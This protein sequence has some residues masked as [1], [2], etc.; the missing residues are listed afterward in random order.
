MGSYNLNKKCQTNKPQ[1]IR[2]TNKKEEKILKLNK[3]IL[4]LMLVVMV[5][6]VKVVPM[7]MLLDL[8]LMLP[9]TKVI[10]VKIIWNKRRKK[11]RRR[12]IKR[13]PRKRSFDLNGMHHLGSSDYNA[14][15]DTHLQSFFVN[16]R[17]RKHLRKMNLITKEGF[18]IE[19]PEEY[20]RNRMLLKEHYKSYS[21]NRGKKSKKGTAG[22]GG[23]YANKENHN[24]FF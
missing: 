23:N 13:A 18:I 15:K 8:T 4:M 16:D 1:K 21:P 17:V 19:K 14:L 7:I 3:M 11:K 9:E 6:M 22:T 10:E 20:R 12:L 24:E 5:K 2:K